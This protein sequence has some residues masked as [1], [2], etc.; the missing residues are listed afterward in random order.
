MKQ[1]INNIRDSLHSEQVCE[2]IKCV[3]NLEDESLIASFEN[4][5]ERVVSQSVN[6]PCRFEYD[7][8]RRNKFM[9][10]LRKAITL[11]RYKVNAGNG[12]SKREKIAVKNNIDQANLTKIY[13]VEKFKK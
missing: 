9:D 13:F 7:D 2:A 12:R 1:E 5:I 6:L 8:S 4:E 11:T 3:S 10:Q